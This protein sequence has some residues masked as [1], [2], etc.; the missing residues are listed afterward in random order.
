MYGIRG[1]AMG[2]K[3]ELADENEED[4]MDFGKLDFGWGG[5]DPE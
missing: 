3:V 1:K 2:Y 4:M 5:L